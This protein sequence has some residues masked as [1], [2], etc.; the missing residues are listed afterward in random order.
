MKP[1]WPDDDADTI[2]LQGRGLIELPGLE[3]CTRVERLWLS[4]NRL[5]A[6]PPGLAGLTSLTTLDLRENP[7]EAIDDGL[8]DRLAPRLTSVL[9]DG[10]RLQHFPPAV[11]RWRLVSLSLR[12]LP[13]DVPWRELLA[14][15][16]PTRLASLQLGGNPG[17]GEAVELLPRFT[18]LRV[19]GLDGCGLTHVPAGLSALTQLETLGLAANELAELPTEVTTLP[20][21]RS[22]VIAKNPGTR[23]IKAALKKAGLRYAVT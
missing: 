7:L 9:L 1:L 15:I 20:S 21:L 5:R 19:L 22:L 16:D 4:G 23:R 18:A 12:N 3:R 11:A 6:L 17:F 8:A 13:A 14:R 10:T 2:S